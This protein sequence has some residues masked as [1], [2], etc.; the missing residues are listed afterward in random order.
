MPHEVQSMLA[1]A[2]KHKQVAAELNCQWVSPDK[3]GRCAC[4]HV[5]AMAKA[6][7]HLIVCRFRSADS[8]TA[9]SPPIEEVWSGSAFMLCGK[10][11]LAITAKHNVEGVDQRGQGVLFACTHPQDDAAPP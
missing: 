7:V 11:K 2:A 1:I 8:T 5:S 6:M 4:E 3:L 10:R 9:D